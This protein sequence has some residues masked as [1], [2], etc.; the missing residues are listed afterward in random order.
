LPSVTTLAV[1]ALIGATVV[2]GVIRT[3]LGV[4]AGIFLTASMSFFF[5]AKR[6]LAIMAILQIAFD[7]SAGYHFRGQWNRRLLVP[8]VPATVAGVLLGTWL[9]AVVPGI[10]IRR[11]MGLALVLYTIVQ[12]L[13]GRRGLREPP[14]PGVAT[15]ILVA[16]LSGAASALVNVSGVILAVYLA[17][18]RLPQ[19]AFLGTLTATQLIQDVFKLGAYWRVGLLGAEEVR[20]SL[21]FVPLIFAG[22][23]I[24]VLLNRYLPAKLFGWMVQGFV[25]LTGIRLLL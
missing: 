12:A 21:P 19:A 1:L 7:L 23:A 10:W 8:M 13:R 9:V 4:G 5:E 20:V 16:A 24:G 11:V 22:G 17:A 25:F 15:G 2:A 3:T 18:L 6:A 14:R